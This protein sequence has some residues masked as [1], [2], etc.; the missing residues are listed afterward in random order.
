MIS[1]LAKQIH[2]ARGFI[3]RKMESAAIEEQGLWELV[4]PDGSSSPFASEEEVWD[5]LQDYRYSVDLCLGFLREQ[6]WP[7]QRM[8]DKTKQGYMWHIMALG[9]VEQYTTSFFEPKAGLTDEQP[10]ALILASMIAKLL[11]EVGPGVLK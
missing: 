11:E 1:D 3:V 5:Y 9:R 4:Y 10:E 7:W 8:W 6:N 2:E